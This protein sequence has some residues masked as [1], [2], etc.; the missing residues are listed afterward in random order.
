MQISDEITY[1]G[2]GGSWKY[3]I[4]NVWSVE[5][6]LD[7]DTYSYQPVGN[8]YNIT[9]TTVET[10]YYL[11]DVWLSGFTYRHTVS[12]GNQDEA[13][14]DENLYAVFLRAVW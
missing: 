14:Y 3:R 5:C 7:Y 9:R 10:S 12:N 11:S 13:N 6:R 2:G 8:G 4:S 1:W